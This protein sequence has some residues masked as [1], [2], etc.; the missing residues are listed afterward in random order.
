MSIIGRNIL[1]TTLVVKNLVIISNM[2]NTVI[3]NT[4]WNIASVLNES[5]ESVYGALKIAMTLPSSLKMGA[6]MV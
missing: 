6:Y 1:S 4:E 5:P 2:K 3:T